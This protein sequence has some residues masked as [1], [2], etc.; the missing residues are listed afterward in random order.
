MS[1][2]D[3]SELVDSFATHGGDSGNAAL[4]IARDVGS[5]LVDG[6]ATSAGWT[7]GTVDPAAVF[8]LN[9]RQLE[10]L[11]EG[12]R[13]RGAVRVCVREALFGVRWGASSS[14]GRR[15]DVIEWQ[16]ACWQITEVDDYLPSGGFGYHVAVRMD[17]PA[18]SVA[19]FIAEEAA[20]AG[21]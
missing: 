5:T 2:F 11:P 9:S 12:I 1:T 7:A 13:E 3:F 15:G 20:E 18:S 16:G 8:P 19:A 10:A 6:I 17:R 14:D 21:A 4:P